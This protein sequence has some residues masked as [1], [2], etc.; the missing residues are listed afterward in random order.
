VFTDG[1]T[2]SVSCPV[3]S[4]GGGS[5]R[6]NPRLLGGGSVVPYIGS[7]TGEA[8]C[9]TDVMRRPDGIGYRDET[10]L[11][12]DQGGVLWT[13]IAVVVKSNETVGVYRTGCGWSAGWLIQATSGNTGGRGRRAKRSGC[14]A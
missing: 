14:A 11:D 1:M 12:R 5:T 3:T 2:G 10:L 6:Y 7:W 8:N 9:R 13:R 4:S